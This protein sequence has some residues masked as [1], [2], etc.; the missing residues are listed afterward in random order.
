[1]P[2]G[3]AI[4]EHEQQ[5]MPARA[6][7]SEQPEAL[8]QSRVKAKQL[9]IDSLR[10][11]QLQGLSPVN[12]RLTF[13]GDLPVESFQCQ[14]WEP[15]RAVQELQPDDGVMMVK[16]FDNISSPDSVA[17]MSLKGQLLGYVPRRHIARFVN[18]TTCG[19]VYAVSQDAASLWR[20]TVACRP[21]LPPLTV[22]TIPANLASY[23]RIGEALNPDDWEAV[24]AVTL[25]QAGYRCRECG[26]VGQLQCRERWRFYEGYQVIKLM[27]FAA[28]HPQVC[29]VKH[30][31]PCCLPSDPRRQ[32]AVALL[33]HINEWC[34]SE[35][36]DYLNY[37]RSLVLQRGK[38]Q[39]TFD[40]TWLTENGFAIP[41]RLQSVC[42]PTIPANVEIRL[43]S[44]EVSERRSKFVKGG[45]CF[46]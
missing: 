30:L 32:H 38:E 35:T 36:E 41:A 12:A 8:A 13:A 14:L 45:C 43:Q 23:A 26:P 5:Q 37:A 40:L 21:E 15:A 29:A 39:W 4:P 2:H 22:D 28:A 18:D 25:Q 6:S 19:H 31:D 33:Q 46:Q 44:K 20:L 34:I 42:G 3:I 16:R 17:V 10:S 11:I 24:Q 9:M 7:A 1:M 27:G